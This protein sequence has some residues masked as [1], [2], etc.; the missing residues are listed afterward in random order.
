MQEEGDDEEGVSRQASEQ[1]WQLLE[2]RGFAKVPGLPTHAREVGGFEIR[3]AAARA[4][5]EGGGGN[6]AAGDGSMAAGGRRRA[7]S[8]VERR[9]L[10][11][12]YVEEQANF[13][14]VCYGMRVVRLDR[15]PL[16]EGQYLPK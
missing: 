5:V 12:K 11:D 13:G 16:V 1:E 10:K 9:R 7:L 8:E 2:A 14:R 4:G 15:G 3:E 6:A